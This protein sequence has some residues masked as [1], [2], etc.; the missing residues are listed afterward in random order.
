MNRTVTRRFPFGLCELM[1]IFVCNYAENV[2]GLPYNVH[3]SGRSYARVSCTP[4]V[5]YKEFILNTET[6]VIASDSSS[7]C[8]IQN[9]VPDGG[10]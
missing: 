8:L 10:I 2:R 9:F 1:H 6:V 7:T 4:L 5:N 3:L